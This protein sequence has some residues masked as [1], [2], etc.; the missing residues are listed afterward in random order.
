MDENLEVELL[1][2]FGLAKCNYKLAGIKRVDLKP[3][4]D[5]AIPRNKQHIEKMKEEMKQDEL[6]EN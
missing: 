4:T 5:S 2:Y 1:D 3:A 6:V